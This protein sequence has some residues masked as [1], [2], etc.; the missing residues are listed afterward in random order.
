MFQ[1]TNQLYMCIHTTTTIT[2]GTTS[3]TITTPAHKTP[4][5]SAAAANV[6]K[7]H[8]VLN[9]V[10]IMCTFFSWQYGGFHKWGYPQIINFK[11][12]FHYKPSNWGYPHLWKP[13]YCYIELSK[14]LL[15][16][17]S[18]VRK[19]SGDTPLSHDKETC[20]P[21][22]SCSGSTQFASTSVMHLSG[23]HPNSIILDRLQQL[24]P[25]T[26]LP[27]FAATNSPMTLPSQG[28]PRFQASPS[29]SLDMGLS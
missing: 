23:I 25:F 24:N 6:S 1:T 17:L 26:Y 4:A 18:G 9:H 15:L 20:S 22:R 16:L 21:E 7:S 29:I 2:A 14:L 19:A 11:G 5:T 13:P 28:F 8:G 12:I 10:W 3:P 27:A